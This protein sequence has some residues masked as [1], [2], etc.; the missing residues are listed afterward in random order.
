MQPNPQF[1]KW[2]VIFAALYGF[3]A[4]YFDIP[5]YISLIIG[6]IYSFGLSRKYPPLN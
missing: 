5:Y 3:P 4:V 2:V 1:L 6:F